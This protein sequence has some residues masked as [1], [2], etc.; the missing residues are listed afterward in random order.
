MMKKSQ[1]S[2]FIIAGILIFIAFS[3]LT[4][5]NDLE[6]EKTQTEPKNI[7]FELAPVK[8]FIESC[9]REKSLEA[10]EFVG[11]KGGYYNDPDFGVDYLYRKVPYYYYLGNDVMPTIR[12]VEES[13]S[14]YIEDGISSCIN[15]FVAF[16][17]LEIIGGDANVNTILNENKVSFNLNYPIAVKK[18]NQSTA[19]LED[20]AIELHVRFIDLYAAGAQ[21][22]ELQIEDSDNIC[23][24]CLA[25]TAIENNVSINLENYDKETIL[26][27][28]ALNTSMQDYEVIQLIFAN[29]Y[30]IK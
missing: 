8:N 22:T 29:K 23:L 16:P 17:G 20:F 4:Y 24:S 6:L 7:Y 30:L 14:D 21:I 19:N 3:F 13:I 27:K 25:D 12:F 1:I 15:D 2:F 10:L 28:V 9:L 11:S 18:G 26:F 5:L